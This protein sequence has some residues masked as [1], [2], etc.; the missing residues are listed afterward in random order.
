MTADDTRYADFFNGS[1]IADVNKIDM[2][3]AEAAAKAAPAQ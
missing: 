2:T 1:L 3:L